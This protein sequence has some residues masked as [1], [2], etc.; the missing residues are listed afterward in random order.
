MPVVDVPTLPIPPEG[1]HRRRSLHHS[2]GGDSG[3][4]SS[5]AASGAAAATSMAGSLGSTNGRELKGAIGMAAGVVTPSIMIP[6]GP[7]FK[8]PGASGSGGSKA[9]FTMTGLLQVAY[10]SITV[11]VSERSMGV[12]RVRGSG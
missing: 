9:T 7:D 1:G 4:A 2:M 5:G 10:A 8:D 11:A 3:S 6:M 12:G